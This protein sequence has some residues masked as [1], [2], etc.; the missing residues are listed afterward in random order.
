MRRRI[1]DA[2][3]ALF[4]EKGLPGVSMRR[5][6]SAVG[7]PTMTLYGYFP[8]K[9]AIV[10][11]LWSHAFQP[12]FEAMREAEAMID[13]PQS[14]LAQVARIYVDYWI[15]HP[16]R[17][18]MV[19]LVEDRLE[20]GDPNWFIDETD[21][22]SSYMRFG[23]LIAAARGTPSEDC[24]IEAEALICA[25]TGIAHMEITVSEYPWAGPQ[26]YVDNI[27]RAFTHRPQPG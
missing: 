25:L 27:L 23:P 21:V 9:T 13:D 7:I 5:I 22:T 19:F 16:D 8:S 6:A 17:Y 2:A 3:K 12:V 26:A 1:I 10:R 20:A 14:R 18:R 24:R 11:G 4:E 15:I